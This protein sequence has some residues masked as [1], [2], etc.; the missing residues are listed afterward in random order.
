ME[1]NIWP[2]GQFNQNQA[3]SAAAAAKGNLT[4]NF[5]EFKH[6]VLLHE[7]GLE[8]QD[9][10][11]LNKPIGNFKNHSHVGKSTHVESASENIEEVNELR[12]QFKERHQ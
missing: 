1:S 3:S 11:N 10:Q 5:Q 9:C 12:M 4:E 6:C 7:K 8:M 2:G